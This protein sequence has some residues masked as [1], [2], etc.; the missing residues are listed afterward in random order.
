MPTQPTRTLLPI[1]TFT[2]LAT[3]CGD[4]PKDPAPQEYCAAENVTAYA[5]GSVGTFNL[6]L[7]QSSIEG[8]T[9]ISQQVLLKLGQV[10]RKEQGDKVPLLMRVFDAKIKSELLDAMANASLNEP[11]I[12][13]VVDA[14]KVTAGSE[15]TRTDLSTYDCS[16]QNDTICVQIGFD[17]NHDG[18]LLNDDDAAF[19]AASGT[20]TIQRAENARFNITWDITLGQN[21]LTFNDTSS[22]KFAGCIQSRYETSGLGN[23]QLR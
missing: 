11:K 22:G 2:L 19:N 18:Q 14:T 3:A 13:T 23:W 5:R 7:E 15:Q 6:N 17:T 8:S 16:I 12:L 9:I 10:A 4:P 20:V 1:L 21:L